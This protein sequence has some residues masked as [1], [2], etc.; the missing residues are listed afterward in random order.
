[1]AGDGLGQVAGGGDVAV[2]DHVHVP[3][4]GLV[5]VV[6]PGGGRVGDRGGHRH[7]DAEHLTGGGGAG[8]RAVAHDHARRA[9]AHQVQRGAVVAHTACHHGHV[10]FGDEGLEVQRLA[11][12]HVLGGDDGAV[13][14]QQVDTG[15]HQ[16]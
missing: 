4:T 12:A 7:A 3:A 10:Q 5:Q 6:A 2:G 15:L 16:A 13:H 11:V 9:G 1:A 8:E 14:H